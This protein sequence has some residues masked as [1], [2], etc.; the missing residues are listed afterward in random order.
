MRGADLCRSR[1]IGA[2][3]D[4]VLE[5]IEGLYMFNENY[6]KVLLSK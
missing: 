2:C 1:H 5:L 6:T 3:F 4:N